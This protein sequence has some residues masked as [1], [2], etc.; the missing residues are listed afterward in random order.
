MSEWILAARE[1]YEAGGRIRTVKMVSRKEA[2][3]LARL[4]GLLEP[5]IPSKPVGEDHC[6]VLT[7]TGRD[8]FDG[9]LEFYTPSLGPGKNG[10]RALGSHRRLRPTWLAALPRAN[11]VQLSAAAGALL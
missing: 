3:R 6:T 8:L 5:T 7:E 4:Q 2:R 1:V 11:Q 10:G 9:R